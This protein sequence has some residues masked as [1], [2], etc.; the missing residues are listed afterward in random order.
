MYV[1]KGGSPLAGDTRRDGR[2][3]EWIRKTVPRRKEVGEITRVESSEM[4][5]HI[6]W[7]A[8]GPI[9]RQTRPIDLEKG[10]SVLIDVCIGLR[11]RL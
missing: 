9:R 2:R 5:S 8:T 3:L 10:S 4:V 1:L 7:S 6:P 11:V